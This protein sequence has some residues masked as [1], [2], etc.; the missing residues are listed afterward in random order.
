MESGE[1]APPSITLSVEAMEKSVTALATISSSSRL[2]RE[3][4]R[5]T[6]HDSAF[7]PWKV[8]IGP[9]DWEDHSNGKEGAE[10]YRTQ[11]LP[12]CTSCTGVYELGTAVWRSKSRRDAG[13][14]DPDFIIP[15]YLGKSDNVRNRLQQYG[16]EGAH[17]ENGSSNTKLNGCNG[18]LAQTGSGLFKDIFSEGF[19]IVYRWAPMK[20]ARDADKTESDLLGKFDYAWN[21]GSNGPRRHNDIL[22]MLDRISKTSPFMAKLQVLSQKKKGIKIKAYKPPFV[23]NGLDFY[24]SLETNGL[25]PQIFK[26][27]RSQPRLIV[28]SVINENYISIC[29]V[30]LGHGVVCKRAPA[31]GNKRCSEH[32]GMKVNG[33]TSKLLKDGKSTLVANEYPIDK[34]FTP[35]CGVILDDGSCCTSKPVQGNKR[36][37]EHKGRKI[38]NFPQLVNDKKANYVYGPVLDYNTSLSKAGH[39]DSSSTICG[40]DLDDGTFCTRQPPAGRKRCEEHKG[41]RIKETICISHRDEIPSS[42]IPSGPKIGMQESQNHSLIP[43]VFCDKTP[44]ACGAATH[45]GS[46]CSRKPTEGNKRCWQHKGMR[47]DASPASG[48]CNNSRQ[49]STS[50]QYASDDFTSTC[51]A[52]LQNG[53]HCS[54]KPTNGNKRCS[55]H[56]GRRADLSPG[57]SNDFRYYANSFSYASHG[58]AY[59]TFSSTCG[60]PT[61]SGSYCRRSTAGGRCWQHEGYANS[62]SYASYG[63]AYGNFSST[64]GAP[65]RSGS[66]CRRSTAG[67]SCWQHGG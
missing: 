1:R 6:K 33:F 49:S 10:R 8:L 18:S 12:N 47:V 48:S 37:L 57:S 24:T 64:C 32:K 15:V 26:F 40:V 23:E 27:G 14:L 58:S 2:K 28:R 21:K 62:Y 45:D 9:S 55:Q 20:S 56:E 31:E 22:K 65:T 53:S 44:P 59:E 66:Y 5:R 52:A 11:N 43:S 4:C 63:S 19:S 29:G 42:F 39:T 35:P 17:L 25:L 3:D 34:T 54:R 51:G 13:K 61:L 60:A 30:A 7:S 38:N 16:R 67:G 50:L 36:C 46:F 41:K